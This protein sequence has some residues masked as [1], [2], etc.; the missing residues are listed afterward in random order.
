MTEAALKTEQPQPYIRIRA[1]TR[2]DLMDKGAFL[3]ARL[4]EKYPHMQ[5]RN[6]HGWLTAC[7]GNN[8]YFFVRSDHAFL[9]AVRTRDFLDLRP[10][11]REVFDLAELRD[12]KVTKGSDAETHQHQQN[13]VARLEAAALYGELLRWCQAIG[14]GELIVDKF[15]DV[16]L[17]DKG[18]EDPGT[19]RAIF[20]TANI[21]LYR[22]EEIFASL[23]P[24]AKIRKLGG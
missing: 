23:D 20:A 21:K 1:V 18:K 15:S 22:G 19:L 8:E 11:V 2:P 16:P 6:I 7:C 3:C 4:R 9:L 12:D 24:N 14:A 17:G 13:A 5:E 10:T